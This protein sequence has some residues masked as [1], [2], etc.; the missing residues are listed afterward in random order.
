MVLPTRGR[1]ELV[2][3]SIQAVVDQTYPGE[4]ECFVVHD[5]EPPMPEL[6]ELGRPGR[7]VTVIE[8]D[9]APGLAGARNVGLDPG[10]RRVRRLL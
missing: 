6:A 3:E 2:R 7:T 10:Q 1:P 4:I 5:Q 9:G 8:N